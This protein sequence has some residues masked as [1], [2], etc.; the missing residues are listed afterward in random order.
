VLVLRCFGADVAWT[1]HVYPSATIWAPWNLVMESNACLGPDVECYN[2]AEVRVGRD[3]VVSQRVFLCTAS[4]DY[5]SENFQLFAKPIRIGARSWIA[6]GCFVGPGVEVGERA[7]LG[8]FAVTSR[9][10]P[11]G[12]VWVGNPASFLKNR[13]AGSTT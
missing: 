5:D 10:I 1:A 9:S 3:A 8:A 12:T 7:V 6:A 11:A 13:G 2:V 4:H